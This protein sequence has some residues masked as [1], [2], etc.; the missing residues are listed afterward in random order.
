MDGAARS[1]WRQEQP[2]AQA[3]VIRD[4]SRAAGQRLLTG[5][6]HCPGFRLDPLS[7]QYEIDAVRRLTRRKVLSAER[8]RAAALE[9][10]GQ[11]GA[12]QELAEQ[13]TVAVDVEVPA[14]HGPGP[15]H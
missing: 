7:G 13:G 4:V 14:H 6:Q 8:R 3:E 2:G 11:A 9:N 5:E 12:C 15:G 10:I 1:R